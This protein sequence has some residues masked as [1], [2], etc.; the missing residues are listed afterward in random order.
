MSR[1]SKSEIPMSKRFFPAL[2]PVLGR[3]KYER[4]QQRYRDLYAGHD[5]PEHPFLRWHLSEGIL[6]GLAFYQVLRESG[7]S[8]QSA[9]ATI[10]RAF[11]SLFSDNIRKMKRLGR[12]PFIYP[13]LRLIIKPAMR[14]Y[15]AEGWKKEWIQNDKKAIRFNMKSCYYHDVLSEYGAPELT[16]SFCRVDDLT[17]ENMSPALLWQRTMTIARGDA[18]CDFCFARAKKRTT[19]K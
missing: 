9:L 15:P 11:V 13:I 10:D 17:Y 12:L 8:Q 3:E 4:V 18:Y 14:P 16:A 7:E 6:P 19:L 2:L 1:D 5:L